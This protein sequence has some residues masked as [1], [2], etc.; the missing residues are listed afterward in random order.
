MAVFPVAPD[1]TPYTNPRLGLSHGHLDATT[2][3]AT[4]RLWWGNRPKAQ[5][6]WAVD[7][8]TL[9]VDIDSKDGRQGYRDFEE[10]EGCAADAVDTPQATTITGGRHLYYA[11]NGRVYKNKVMI[12]G[13]GLD[14]R[15]R[16]GYVVLPLRATGGSGLSR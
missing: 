5:V 8:D 13:S 4:I 15:A 9:V 7:A 14:T 6:G 1:K 2:D 10:R 3:P 16:G 11:A 12:D